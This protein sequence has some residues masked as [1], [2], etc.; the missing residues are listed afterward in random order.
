MKL[1]LVWCLDDLFQL[2]GHFGSNS[3]VTVSEPNVGVVF[4]LEPLLPEAGAVSVL[5][6]LGPVEDRA[7]ELTVQVEVIVDP[8]NWTTG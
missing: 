8:R 5:D 2:H 7:E 3:Q 4:P 1:I 6:L